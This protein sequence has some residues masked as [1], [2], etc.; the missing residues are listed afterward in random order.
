MRAH[1]TAEQRQL[2]LRLKAR[3]LSPREIGPQAG[4]SHRGAT[5]VVRQAVADRPVLGVCGRGRQ[6]ASSR[7]RVFVSSYS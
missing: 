1:L 5:L 6:L 7:M 3:G 4:C 2:A